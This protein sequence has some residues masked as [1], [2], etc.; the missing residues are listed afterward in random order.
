MLHNKILFDIYKSVKFL[1]KNKMDKN[2]K[3][4]NN[5]IKKYHN[6]KLYNNYQH[7]GTLESDNDYQEIMTNLDSIENG[8]LK[9]FQSLKG[10]IEIYSKNA[11]KFEKILQD[12]LSLESLKK[13]KDSMNDLNEVLDKLK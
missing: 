6:S 10:Y 5:I 3:K 1:D 2:T 8:I 11:E 13:L 9:Y 7:G 12:R 4:I